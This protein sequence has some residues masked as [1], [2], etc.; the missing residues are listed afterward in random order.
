MLSYEDIKN[1]CANYKIENGIVIEKNS[2]R[3]IN[4]EDIVLRVKSSLLIF[5]E[6]HDTYKNDMRQF[7]KTNKSQDDYI[8]K[9]MEK[10]GTNGEVN[11]YGINKLVNAIL[12]SNGHYE[13]MISGS[14][15]QNGKFSMLVPPKQDYG[16]AYLRLK[17]REK[18][19]DIDNLKVSQD[20]TEL[21]HNGVSK[22]IID[23][24]IKK[25]E[26]I[27][28]NVN[29]HDLQSTNGSDI[30]QIR[31]NTVDVAP[32]KWD[33]MSIDEQISYIHAKMNESRSLHDQ[34]SYNYWNANLI[35]LQ[36]KKQER[37]T[38]IKNPLN[39]SKPPS[40][41]ESSDYYQGL[42]NAINRRRTTPSLTEEEKKE[43]VGEIYYNMDYL[44]QK[45]N[46]DKEIMELLSKVVVDL[47][48]DDFERKIQNQIISDIQNK[49]NKTMG[50]NVRVVDQK[51]STQTEKKDLF[52]NIE[53][54]KDKLKRLQIEYHDMLSDGYIDDNELEMLIR[55]MSELSNDADELM[56]FATT[57][58]ERYILNSIIDTIN[59]EKRKMIKSQNSVEE[60]SR[61]SK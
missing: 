45:I 55:K 1:Y 16:L 5:S 46:T 28:T 34:D 56:R 26:K 15:L 41:K 22:V 48:N 10:F 11:T 32:I 39:D 2:D 43:I 58:N 12:A 38:S 51:Q 33:S 59:D 31:Q 40:K 44:V 23:F 19:L 36:R 17:F 47:N 30:N 29:T 35:N 57:S 54:L 21:K 37:E 25:Y 50:E 6:A 4:D 13:E 18:G 27:V 9:T 52:K 49:R 24:K 8:T 61:G 60:M 14:E 53:M 42:M 7:G 20:L 3:Q